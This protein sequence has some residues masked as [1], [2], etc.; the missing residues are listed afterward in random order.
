L[1]HTQ[2][3]TVNSTLTLRSFTDPTPVN[4]PYDANGNPIVANRNGF[5]T[6]TAVRSPRVVQ[7]LV[8]LE[9]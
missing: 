6:V 7:L 5:G 2:F 3:D 1:N 8:R 4:L 9:F